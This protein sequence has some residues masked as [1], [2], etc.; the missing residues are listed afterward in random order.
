M[1]QTRGLVV[2]D[3]SALYTQLL[4]RIV[5]GQLLVG[6]VAI[7]LLSS[8]DEPHNGLL[9]DRIHAGTVVEGLLANR[10]IEA[11]NSTGRTRLATL[12]DAEILQHAG[13]LPST[14]PTAPANRPPVAQ[15]DAFS[16]PRGTT[17]R[18]RFTQLLANDSDPDGDRLSVVGGTLPRFGTVTPDADGGGGLYTPRA[19]FVG[20]DS[21]SYT[22]HDGRGGSATATVTLTVR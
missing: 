20:S 22:I 19:G 9:G 2:I 4:S 5:N 17:L 15:A 16:L 3:S 7:Q 1:A 14:P 18:I 21:I 10:Y 8:G 11:L 12:S 6:G 13:L